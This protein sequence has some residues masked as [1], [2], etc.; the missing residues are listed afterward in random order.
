VTD[1]GNL[2]L[3]YKTVARID[4]SRCIQCNLCYLVC[5]S[6]GCITMARVDDGSAPLTWRELTSR[7]PAPTSGD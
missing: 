4:Y 3:N 6:P 2:D 7:E 5:P 1:W